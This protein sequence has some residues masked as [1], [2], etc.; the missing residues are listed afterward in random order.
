MTPRGELY[1]TVA[2]LLWVGCCC[3]SS[4]GGTQA[5]VAQLEEYSPR[6]R[7]G[8]GSIPAWGPDDA[9]LAR[10]CWKE[11]SFRLSDCAAIGYVLQARAL[12]AGW[13]FERMARSYASL[14]ADSERAARARAL[15]DSDSPSFTQAENGRWALVRIVARET[16][17]GRA[18]N[19]CPKARHWGATNLVPD[20]LRAAGALRAGRWVRVSCRPAT[21]NAFYRE[22]RTLGAAEA[23]GR[24]Q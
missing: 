8:V 15:P 14:G 6:K 19:P 21:A 20:V 5:P 23:A 12:R 2:F 1:L 11:A 17:Q 13:T 7:V 3:A 4:I 16:M 22:A 10:V 9:V 24:F 18:A